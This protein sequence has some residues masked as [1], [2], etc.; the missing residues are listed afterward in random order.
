MGV[1]QDLLNLDNQSD[2]AQKQYSVEEE[3]F[4][5]AILASSPFPCQVCKL[6]V[7]E[8][9]G[10]INVLEIREEEGY[11]TGPYMVCEYC[12][13][14]SLHE[15]DKLDSKLLIGSGRKYI[16]KDEYSTSLSEE[17]K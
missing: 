9:L 1:L 17:I 10:I 16:L 4:G 13:N 12:F 7:G 2:L 6:D 14:L 11:I 8:S 3:A 15:A 5:I